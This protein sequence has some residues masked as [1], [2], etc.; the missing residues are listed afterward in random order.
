MYRHED[1]EVNHTVDLNSECKID[2]LYEYSTEYAIPKVKPGRYICQ[3][4]SKCYFG[5]SEMSEKISVWNEEDVSYSFICPSLILI[6]HFSVCK[7]YI[8]I[9]VFFYHHRNVLISINK[10][11]QLFYG[12]S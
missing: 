1:D 9:K 8:T 11:I 7:M 12:G 3:M 10:L 5:I 6:K 2:N 4:Q